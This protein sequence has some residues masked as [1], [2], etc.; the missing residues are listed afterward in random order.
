MRIYKLTYGFATSVFLT[1]A[2]CGGG[3]SSGGGSGVAPPPP[4]LP[5]PPPTNQAPRITSPTNISFEENIDVTFTVEATDPEGS[6]VS[7]SLAQ[8][9]DSG[10][11]S[12]DEDTGIVTTNIGSDPF[13][14]ENPLDGNRDN[15][16]SIEITVS[17]G[18]LSSTE[19]IAITIT[20]VDGP[21]TCSTGDTATIT[22]NVRGPF[23]T[24]EANKPDG[25]A[26]AIS[27]DIELMYSRG[28]AGPAN[29]DLRNSIGLVSSVDGNNAT[30]SLT[31]RDIINAETQ[32]NLD[33]FHTIST[34][35]ELDGETVECIVEVQ[36]VDVENE[37]TEGIKFS[38]SFPNN[39]DM[40]T[41]Q[42]GDIDQDGLT[43]I[44]LASSK[45]VT[46]EPWD[47][48]GYLIFGKTLQSEL[49]VDGAEEILLDS[50]EPT[51]AIKIFGDFPPI[52]PLRYI[53]NNLAAGPADDIDGDGIPELLLTL[54]T[55]ADAREST[56]F[57]RPLSYIIWGDAIRGQT[58]GELNLDLLAPAEGLKFEGV[59]G[60]NRKG[61]VSVSGDFDGDGIADVAI[62]IAAESL[63]ATDT[64]KYRGLVF[65]VFGDYIRASKVDGTIDILDDI[66]ALNPKQIIILTAE[67][68]DDDISLPP[69][70]PLLTSAGSQLSVL[71]DI[72][73]DGADELMTIGSNET[74]FITDFGIISSQALKEAKTGTGLIEYEDIAND[75]ITV[76]ETPDNPILGDMSGDVDNDNLEDIIVATIDFYTDTP[77]A[78]MVPGS[79]LANNLPGNIIEPNGSVPGVIKFDYP[80]LDS[81]IN[82]ASVLSD[83][84]GDNQDD[85][86]LSYFTTTATGADSDVIHRVSIVLA[87]SFS[88]LETNE[89]FRLD[90]M[91]AGEGLHILNASV[92]SFGGIVTNLSD[93]DG[94]NIPDISIHTKDLTS[95]FRRESY[96][97]SGENLRE[98]ILSGNV[99]YDL[100]SKFRNPEP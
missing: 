69:E 32:G 63:I 18:E 99:N 45:F 93:V 40:E 19:T 44:F 41:Y 28:S 76:F 17:D 96:V 2:G 78:Y 94:D 70:L 52:S 35:A 98:A 82:Q 74:Q 80:S 3:S 5:P 7:I 92:S 11:F 58:D 64:S 14:F 67:D 79:T 95:S 33:E 30:L 16:Y 84:D 51:Q 39:Y 65:I 25:V 24:F 37:V 56:F 50:L 9:G 34:Q 73:G 31:V 88:T 43:D 46:D 85:I 42:V 48:Q 89:V 47:H 91:K 83:L 62:G 68:Q 97:I 100:D 55:P 54:E 71:S 38:G 1:L 61:N 75:H 72:D 8:D 77:L 4:P 57:D 21:L 36:I 53:G 15:V 81:Q 12:L 49:L 20:D 86:A 60:I 87:K 29:E 59:G 90:E 10:L 13:N 6:P 23:Y 22:E 27:F 66:N 26:G